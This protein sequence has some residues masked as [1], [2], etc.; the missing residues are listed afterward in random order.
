MIET[1]RSRAPMQPQAEAEP[2]HLGR[3]RRE[4]AK[5]QDEELK[6]VETKK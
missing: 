5:P 2:Q 6:Q 4:R 1:D 3:A